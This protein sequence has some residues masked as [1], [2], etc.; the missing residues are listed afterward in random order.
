MGVGTRSKCFHLIRI[1]NKKALWKTE[2]FRAAGDNYVLAQHLTFLPW[3]KLCL[4]KSPC[5]C[6]PLRK[7]TAQQR[8][9][10]HDNVSWQSEQKIMLNLSQNFRLQ[11]RIFIWKE[12]VL[13][14]FSCVVINP[15]TPTTK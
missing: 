4:K 10:C 11:C 7:L 2:H 14:T 12:T 6:K 5:E 15:N 1:H 3:E 13:H 8:M 9:L